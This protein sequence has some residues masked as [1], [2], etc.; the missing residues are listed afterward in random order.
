MVKKLWLKIGWI[1]FWLCLP[2]L[3]VYLRRSNDRPRIL[4]TN[5][6]KVLLVRSWLGDGRWHLPG[7]G[8]K[9]NEDPKAGA[10]RELFEETGLKIESSKVHAR[11][12]H[13]QINDLLQFSYHLFEANS[14]DQTLPPHKTAEITAVAWVSRT[15][16]EP[17]NAQQHVL[18][19]LNKV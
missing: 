4:V 3:F 12:K 14:K 17:G 9:H 11:G 2:A 1:G 8:L 16:L 5:K 18:D 19:A 7:G 10:L 15:E 6:D 13:Q